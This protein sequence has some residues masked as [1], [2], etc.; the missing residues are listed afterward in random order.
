MPDVPLVGSQ[1][2]V[3]A[4]VVLVSGKTGPQVD[5]AIKIQRQTRRFLDARRAINRVWTFP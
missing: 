4:N 2:V 3:T 5:A 1:N